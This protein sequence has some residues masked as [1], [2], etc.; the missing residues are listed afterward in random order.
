MEAKIQDWGEVRTAKILKNREW[1]S[2]SLDEKRDKA[3]YNTVFEDEEWKPVVLKNGYISPIYGVSQ[4]G[5]PKNMVTNQILKV[6]DAFGSGSNKYPGF[7]MKIDIEEYKEW[8]GIDKSGSQKNAGKT[9]AFAGTC[10]QFVMNTW[11]PFDENLIP[12]LEEWWPQFSPQL[13]AIIRDSII[14]DHV[15]DDRWNNHVDNL[16]YTTQSENNWINKEAND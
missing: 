14:I 7:T 9:F 15:D 8:T 12:E 11:K 13:K 2:L 10:H 5:K 16:V 1:L 6:F 4:Y 3:G